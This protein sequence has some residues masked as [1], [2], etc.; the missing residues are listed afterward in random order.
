MIKGGS[1]EI[2]GKNEKAG[3]MMGAKQKHSPLR[4]AVPKHMNRG[5]RT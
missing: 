3:Q 4:M 2:P 5:D 1:R